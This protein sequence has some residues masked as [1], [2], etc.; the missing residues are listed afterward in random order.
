MDDQQIRSHTLD[1]KP[2]AEH[3]FEIPLLVIPN[4]MTRVRIQLSPDGIAADDT[5]YLVLAGEQPSTVVLVISI[6][7]SW[8]TLR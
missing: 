2:G 8:L 6:L 4:R 7:L 5:F 3:T 1:L